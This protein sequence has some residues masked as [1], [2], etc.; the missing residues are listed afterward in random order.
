M[1]WTAQEAQYLLC[2][3]MPHPLPDA[4]T[5]P[6]MPGQKSQT[7]LDAVEDDRLEGARIGRYRHGVRC[8]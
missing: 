7:L 1:L 4:R 2:H 3:L 6:E 8:E 5:V